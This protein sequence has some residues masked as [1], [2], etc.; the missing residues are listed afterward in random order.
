MYEPM[1]T[2]KTIYNDPNQRTLLDAV[3][4]NDVDKIKAILAKLEDKYQG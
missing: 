2:D 1:R 3:V 4:L